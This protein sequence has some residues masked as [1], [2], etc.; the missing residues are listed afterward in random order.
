MGTSSLLRLLA[1]RSGWGL[2]C[3]DGNSKVVEVVTVADVD[4]VDRFENS[5]LHIW[6]LRFG[7]EGKLLF[8]GG[9]CPCRHCRRQCKVFPSGVNFP[10][11][12]NCLCFFLLKLLKLGEIDGV[13]FLA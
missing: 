5:L 9:I 13:K 2:T 12:T 7:H 8:R 11:F 4:D 3:E 1:L 6:K 10:I